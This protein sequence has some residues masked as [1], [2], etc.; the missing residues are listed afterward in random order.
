LTAIRAIGFAVATRGTAA[1]EAAGAPIVDPW[2][3]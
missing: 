3:R 2:I 1:F